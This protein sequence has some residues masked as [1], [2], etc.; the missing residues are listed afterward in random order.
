MDRASIFWIDWRESMGQSSLW[1]L[2]FQ[3]K[4]GGQQNVAFTW[5]RSALLAETFLSLQQNIS[6]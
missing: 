1:V 4:N 6:K 5:F 2:S 3:N